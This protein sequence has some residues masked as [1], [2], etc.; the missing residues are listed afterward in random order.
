LIQSCQQHEIIFFNGALFGRGVLCAGVFNVACSSDSS[1]LDL[2]VNGY[3]HTEKEIGSFTVSRGDGKGGIG[4]EVG[5]LGAG[6]GGGGLTCCVSVPR[7]WPPGMTVKVTWDGWD[8]NT[9]KTLTRVV[10]VP[11]YDAK[12][13]STFDVHFLHNGEVKVFVA[14]YLLGHP[15]YAAQRQGSGDEARCSNRDF[16]PM[17]PIW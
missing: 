14:A 3:N 15:D 16:W 5:Y 7:V 2:S 11:Q 13:A 8:K 6:S 10:P 12:K 17:T 4:I 1:T 9:E